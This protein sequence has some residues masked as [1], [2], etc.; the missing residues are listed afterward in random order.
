MTD[1]KEYVRA[2]EIARLTGMSVRTVR[3][4]IADEILPSTRLGGA[5]LVARADLERL[6]CAGPEGLPKH[7]E[8]TDENYR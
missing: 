3:R 7:T 4:W 2:A 6:L 8:S 5:R 1:G